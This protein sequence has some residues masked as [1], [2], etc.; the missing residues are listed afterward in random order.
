MKFAANTITKSLVLILG[1]NSYAIASD[2]PHK[3]QGNVT[4]E[5]ITIFGQQNSYLNPKVSTATKTDIAL[6][7]HRVR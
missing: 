1:I 4:D 7:K 3:T 6:L 2:Q 5:T